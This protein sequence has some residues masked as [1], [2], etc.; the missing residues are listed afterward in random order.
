MTERNAVI[1]AEGGTDGNRELT[2]AR[3]VRISQ[4]RCRQTGRLDLEHRQVRLSVDPS[5]LSF[6]GSAVLQAHLDFCRIFNYMAVSKNVAVFA[7][8][9]PGSLPARRHLPHATAELAPKLFRSGVFRA[10]LLLA[11]RRR[12]GSLDHSNDDYGRRDF[13]GHLDELLVKLAS[14]VVSSGGFPG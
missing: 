6:E 5:D 2:H 12:T 3:A 4:G 14:Q 7:K 8:D 9:D 1:E 10:F 13:F 11:H